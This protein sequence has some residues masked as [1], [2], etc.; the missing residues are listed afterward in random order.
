MF[1]QAAM[2]SYFK[3]FCVQYGEVKDCVSSGFSVN[4][5]FVLLGVVMFF[6]D[7]LDQLLPD[8]VQSKVFN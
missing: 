4:L 8:Q 3:L 1:W 6:L 5:S 2:K 7:V